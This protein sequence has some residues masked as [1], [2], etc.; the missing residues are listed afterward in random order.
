MHG[1]NNSPLHT[2]HLAKWLKMSVT[3]GLGMVFH[4]GCKGDERILIFALTFSV[5]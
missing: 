3:T 1:K 4:S 2:N 5:A